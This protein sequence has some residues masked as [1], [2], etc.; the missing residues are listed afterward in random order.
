MKQRR[1]FLNAITTFAQVLTSAAVLFFLYRF[2]LR[3]IGVEKLGIWAL[4][5]ATT[6]AVTLAS[7]GFSTSIVKFVAKYAA[8]EESES[9]SLL[10]QTAILAT[11]G[12]IGVASILLYPV[13]KFILAF[14]VPHS[15][16]AEAVVILPYALFSLWL[17]IVGSIALA[18]LIGH[19]L[20]TVRNFVVVLGSA[21]Y[22]TLAFALVPGHGL[23]G[24]AIAQVAQA[25]LI[26]LTTWLLLRRQVPSL[27]LIPHRWDGALFRE[28]LG[29]GVNFQLITLSQC[30]REPIIKGLLSKFGG[31]A[32]T[33]FYDMAGR[34]IFTFRELI[35]QAN[36]VLVPT[37]SGLTEKNPELLPQ[38]YRDSY[39]VISFLAIPIFSFLMVMS[40]V[41]SKLWI[42]HYEHLFVTFSLLLAAGWLINVL[43]NPA[44]VIY[45]GTG[46]LRWVAVGNLVAV[47]LTLVLGIIFGMAFG[48][49]A[50]VM[51]SMIALIIGYLMIPAAYHRAT[52]LSLSVLMPVENVRAIIAGSLG[53]LV[54]IPLFISF[55]DR[56][57]MSPVFLVGCLLA[58]VGVL[59][60][61]LWM[62][63]M[64]QRLTRWVVSALPATATA[65]L[66]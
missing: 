14:V 43:A 34:W 15:R 60:I 56:S 4:V 46:T 23:V 64:R 22:M 5:L 63:P 28:M 26:L 31:L 59:L 7:Q 50:V 51:A 29:Y 53:L 30:V 2:L 19:E 32:Y 10:I 20:I 9:V 17:N 44:Y 8:L 66:R 12:A 24:L 41:V 54:F 61:P 58:A 21:F 48:G 13:A 39:R 36:Q 47:G 35:V 3:T 18:G 37:V 40:P 33:G 16:L 65:Y 42:G 55:R 45:L 1:L 27:S 57:L 38:V 52:S 6:S 49:T 11:A 62:N 25:A